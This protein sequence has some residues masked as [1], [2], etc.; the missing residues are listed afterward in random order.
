MKSSLEKFAGLMNANGWIAFW[1]ILWLGLLGGACFI[2][3]PKY[4]L[5]VGVILTA[6]AQALA[7]SIGSESGRKMPQQAGDPKPGQTTESETSTKSSAPPPPA[8]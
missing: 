4:A 1:C 3:E 5:G 7:N 2:W 6:L 8:T